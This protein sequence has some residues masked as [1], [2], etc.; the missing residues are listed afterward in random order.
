[1]KQSVNIIVCII[2]LLSI[3]C[4]KEQKIVDRRI[5]EYSVFAEIPINAI[6]PKGWLKQYLINQQNGLTS[7]LNNVYPCNVGAWSK[8]VLDSLRKPNP[9]MWRFE[10]T[11]YLTDG[12]LSCGYLLNDSS[13]INKAME[14]INYTLDHPD[15]G[16]YLGNPIIKNQ[17]WAHS[18]FFRAVKNYYMVSK[19][20][21][22]LTA[23]TNHYLKE[24]YPHTSDIR[25]S[26]NIEDI[27][28]LYNELRDTTLLNY[29][30]KIYKD[31]D[32]K[33]FKYEKHELVETSSADFLK[34]V[35]SVTHGV[36]YFERAKLGAILYVATGKKEYL[37]PSV[38]AFKK[39]DKYHMMVDG[40]PCTSESL[41]APVPSELHETCVIGDYSWAIGYV[42]MAT[43]EASY[44]DKIERAMFNAAPGAVTS[45]F[46][47]VQYFSGPNQT[48]VTNSS[49]HSVFFGG[50]TYMQYMP[51]PHTECCPANVNR[52]MP[53]F[54][55]RLWMQDHK[56]GIVASMYG[57]SQL[58]YVAGAE[59][60]SV[61][62]DEN[63]NYPFD[64]KIE[65]VINTHN[66][67]SV[68]FPFTLRIP[69]WCKSPSIK[70]NGV[71]ISENHTSGKYV[72]LDKSFKNGD[73][74]TAEFPQEIKLTHWAR[75]GVAVERGPLL[76]ALK[77]QQDFQIDPTEKSSN[78]NFPAYNIYPI[79]DWNY[80]LNIDPL[81]LTELEVVKKP[82]NNNP[83]SN[84]TAPIEIKV[85]AR[86]VKGW[87]LIRTN[88]F[89]TEIWADGINAL[90]QHEWT[91]YDKYTVK[92]DMILTPKIPEGKYLS[93]KLALENEMI[94]LVPY[95]CT[96]L[97]LTIFP[98]ATYTQKPK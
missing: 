76:Y 50:G 67:A 7:F 63:T 41:R 68:A 10:Q 1:M 14:R 40:V 83:W 45:D 54:V 30:E 22:V 55:S 91:H 62:I 34:D 86:K 95:G 19:D 42:L 37:E 74:I 51:A 4:K 5:P 69:G 89:D 81:Q 2:F 26:I 77:I 87:E 18:V 35:P 84:E 97:R 6:K 57:S 3:S 66:K 38:A 79:S 59:G 49:C 94:T 56:G 82:F 88:K 13:L 80:A 23:L 29:A 92:G 16:G 9:A 60:D 17:R 48:V 28:W 15:T 47:A 90:G 20:P 53:N 43:G 27:M 11:A 73:K 58:N 8:P 21:K 33:K 44:A 78:K 24:C 32:E 46:K 85:P 25:E 39:A 93:K 98:D 12:Q 96:K 36:T 65:F 61:T 52:F 31:A 71:E 72:T 70:I 64:E 75:N